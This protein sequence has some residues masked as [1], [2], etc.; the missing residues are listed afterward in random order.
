MSVKRHIAPVIALLMVVLF[1]CLI[2]A[3]DT[4]QVPRTRSG[5]PDLQGIWQAYGTA[6]WN[7][8]DHAASY[9][10]PAGRSVVVGAEIP[11]QPWARKQRDENFRQRRDRDPVGQC[12]MAG[13]PRITTMPFPLQIFQGNNYVAMLSEYVHT[14]RYIPTDGRAHMQDVEFWMGDSRG[15]WE[16][17][18]LVVDVTNFTDQTW[19]DASG[20]F[21]SGKLHVVE[22]YTRIARDVIKYQVSIEDPKVFTRQW[23]IETTLQLREEPGLQLL[24]YACYAYA[25]EE[26]FGQLGSDPVNRRGTVNDKNK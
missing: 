7:L 21:H 8:E 4:Y 6:A 13:V 26:G 18:T 20:N 23:N 5:V 22:S 16:G 19:L 25:E 17:D 14:T 24:E 11:Y 9:Q 10:L 1:P 12:Y 3:A 2:L 15:H